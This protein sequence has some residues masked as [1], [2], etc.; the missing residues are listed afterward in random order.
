MIRPLLQSKTHRAVVMQCE[1]HYEGSCAMDEDLL[2][3]VTCRCKWRSLHLC[4]LQ[5]VIP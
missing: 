5:T 2:D 1:L 3:A 4:D